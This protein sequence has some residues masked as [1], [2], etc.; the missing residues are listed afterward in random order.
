MDQ[1]LVYQPDPT[2]PGPP[3][4]T[5]LLKINPEGIEPPI[6]VCQQVSCQRENTRHSRTSAGTSALHA[7]VGHVKGLFCVFTWYL[8]QIITGFLRLIWIK[9]LLRHISLVPNMNEWNCY[10][11]SCILLCSAL[12][13]LQDTMASNKPGPECCANVFKQQR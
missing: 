5:E 2:E 11:V 9:T 12:M 4:G 7:C 3:P 1:L 10:Y 6:W 13:G 8:S